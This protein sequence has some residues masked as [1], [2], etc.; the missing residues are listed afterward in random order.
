MAKWRTLRKLST[1]LTAQM[2][3]FM[4]FCGPHLPLAVQFGFG[5]G[6]GGTA[7]KLEGFPS[8][9]SA[10][11]GGRRI[12]YENMVFVGGPLLKTIVPYGLLTLGQ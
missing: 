11:A 8:F 4:V 3:I 12:Q 9:G 2:S 1:F 10:A 7:N 6:G 5:P